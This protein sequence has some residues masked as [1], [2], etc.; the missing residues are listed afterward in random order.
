MHKAPRAQ[1]DADSTTRLVAVTTS[2]RTRR[3]RGIELAPVTRARPVG[4]DDHVAAGSRRPLA[5]AGALAVLVTLGTQG[6]LAGLP[7]RLVPFAENELEARVLQPL[8][9]GRFVRLHPL[10]IVL[11]P[12][13][14]TTVGGI[15]GVLV[16]LPVT[17]VLYNAWGPPRGRPV[18]AGRRDPR[19]D[20]SASGVG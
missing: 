12:A 4:V 3:S 6:L 18:A 14:G 1:P 10:A 20:C 13:I 17:G 15:T 19:R 8:V 9:V 11:V 2:T 7:L 16:A 5:V